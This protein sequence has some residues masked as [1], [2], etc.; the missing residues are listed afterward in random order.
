MHMFC[1][2]ALSLFSQFPE[3]GLDISQLSCLT[4]I[5]ALRIDEGSTGG[6]DDEFWAALCSL[7]GL[8]S[9]GLGE[10]YSGTCSSSQPRSQTYRRNVACM[11]S[12]SS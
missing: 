11:N 7:T 6:Q 3:R 9:L 4:H 8:K 10:L 5:T 1:L 12:G 2:S